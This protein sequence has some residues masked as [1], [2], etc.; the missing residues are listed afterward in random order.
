VKESGVTATTVAAFLTETLKALKRDGVQ[1]GKVSEDQMREIFM[2]IGSGELAKEAVANV[3]DWL[4]K[5]E[6]KSL[7]DAMD[8]LAL[9][10]FSKAEL[11]TLVDRVIAENRQSVE[12]LGNNA[13]GVLMGMVMKEVRGRADPKLVGELLRERLR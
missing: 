3:F 2:C 9:K 6:G 11:E 4:S 7:H 10:M 12:K 1:V 13:F 8:I 5:H